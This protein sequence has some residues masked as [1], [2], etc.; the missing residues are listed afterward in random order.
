M[1]S[2]EE[3][4]GTNNIVE[5]NN[6]LSEFTQSWADYVFLDSI[7]KEPPSLEEGKEKEGKN[8][9]ST[10]YKS[11]IFEKTVHEETYDYLMYVENLQLIKEFRQ[12]RTWKLELE[13]NEYI[14]RNI[15]LPTSKPDFSSKY[16]PSFSFKGFELDYSSLD[17]KFNLTT[18]RIDIELDI[19]SLYFSGWFYIGKNLQKVYEEEFPPF[20][21]NLCILQNKQSGN[22]VSFHVNKN[23]RYELPGDILNEN[24]NND[25]SDT[26]ITTNVINQALNTF[27][28]LDE[29]EYW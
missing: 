20:D 1:Q 29:G 6:N 28:D 13:G 10:L 14:M 8:P 24:Q 2:Y 15:I 25:K 12:G 4:K 3:K 22:L 5:N 26:L 17:P 9:D 21:D 23:A 18:C 16:L 27:G 11:W 19:E 7:P